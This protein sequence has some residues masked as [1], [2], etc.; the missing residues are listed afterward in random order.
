MTVAVQCAVPTISSPQASW[1][2]HNARRQA[3]VG[4]RYAIGITPAMQALIDPTDFDDPIGGSSC[5]IYAKLE[6]TPEERG[7]PSRPRPAARSKVSC[8]VIPTGFC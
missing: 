7:D 1:R 6:T 5:R 3:A 8:I 4:A 2:P